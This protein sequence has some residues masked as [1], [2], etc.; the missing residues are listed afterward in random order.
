[1]N[2]DP[3][4]Q[5]NKPLMDHSI[6]AISISTR[7]RDIFPKGKY[8]GQVA[9]VYTNAANFSFRDHLITV[10]DKAQGNLPYGMLCDLA[11]IDLKQ[12]LHSGD[13]SE[14]DANSLRVD[15]GSFEILFQG[16]EEWT[17]EFRMPIEKKELPRI[18]ANVNSIEQ[19][20]KQ[21]EKMEGLAPLI[22]S[23]SQIM[24]SA[25][26]D[27]KY[28]SALEHSAF[29]SLRNLTAAI[30][31]R[32]EAMIGQAARGLIGLG[33]GLTPSG[34]DVLAGLFG[35][36][37]IT[38]REKDRERLLAAYQKAISNISGLT[39]DVSISTLAAVG[40]GYYPERFS[41]L[42]AAII[43]SKEPKGIDIPLKE[44]LRWG[45]SSGSEIILGMVMGFYLAVEG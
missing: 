38:M 18:R 45:S 4:A 39:T 5:S 27:T 10:A 20:L 14:I 11:K 1:L 34:D 9:G 24:G 43:G 36:L 8:P 30:R 25:S 21:N 29:D 15:N 42:A 23:I 32:D 35:T 7:I 31:V 41:K 28:Y 3:T 19:Q 2:R 37:F 13:P 33:I 44:M 12:V 22:A 17:P 16:A 26:A 6:Q 40:E